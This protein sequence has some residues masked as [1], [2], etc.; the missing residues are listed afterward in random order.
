MR[1]PL[2]NCWSKP[3]NESNSRGFTLIELLVVIAIIAILA[4]MLLPALSR[5]K[6]KAQNT[7]DFNNT[8][9]IM[10]A[11]HLYTTDN[12]EYMPHPTW[13][14]GGTGPDGWAYKSSI[15]SRNARAVSAAQLEAQLTNQIEAFKQGQLAKYLETHQV[16]ICPKDKVESAGSKKSL[17]LQREIK[18]TSYTWNGCIASYMAGG[19]TPA[20][21]TQKIN[22][23]KPT[24]F[25]QWET[26]ELQPFYFND[27]GNQPT[28]GISQR[29]GGGNTK[30]I[31]ADVK[32]SSAVGA[33]AGHAVN[34]KYRTFYQ[35]AGGPI[36]RIIPAPNDVWCDPAG[37]YGGAAGP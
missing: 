5:A 26:D 9:Q 31:N 2:A 25:I 4:S 28:E 27:A 12:E 32:G 11:T 15:M 18:I 37:R 8:K 36:T 24:N 13:G 19:L 14:G 23:F 17:Y 3:Q 21:K 22:A 10:L 34:L 6:D 29:H 33:V 30:R 16:L 20:G 7:L 35:M 1:T